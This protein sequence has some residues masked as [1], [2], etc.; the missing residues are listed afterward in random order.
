LAVECVDAWFLDGFSPAKNPEMW[1]EPVLMNIARASKRKATLATY[2]SA[3]WVRRGLQQVGFEVE[4]VT[5]F[6]SKREMV[7]GRLVGEDFTPSP[8][9]P[10]IE[11]ELMCN[12]EIYSGFNLPLPTGEGM[13]EGERSLHTSKPNNTPRTALIIG[14]GIAGCAAAYALAQRGISVTLFDKATQ[15]ASAASGNPRG[16]LHARFGAGDNPLQRFVLASYGHALGMLD[17]LLPADGKFR[18]E[19][20]LLQLA[21]NEIEIKRINKLAKQVW[22]EHLLRFVDA[23]TATQLAGVE[24]KFGGLWFSA[25]GWIVP[26]R[27]CENLLNDERITQR[28]GHEVEALEK[29][30]EGWRIKGRNTQGS[31]WE[32]EADVVLVC[33][34]HSAKKF[35]QFAHFPLIPVRGQITAVPQSQASRALQCV[36]CGDGYCAP[37]I[38]GVHVTGATHAFEDESS[39]VR[40]SDHAENL[41]NLAEY[42]PGLMQA[43]AVTEVEK[44]TGRAAIRCSAPGSI[45]LVGEVQE[46]LYCSLAH[47]TRGM[48]TAGLA[49]EL[50][51]AQICGQLPPLPVSI[52]EALAPKSRLR[53]KGFE[54]I[55]DM[56]GANPLPNPPPMGEG[57]KPLLR[58]S[59]NRTLSPR[60]RAGRG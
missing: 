49:G 41:A 52:V 14:A 5:G 13:R 51:A 44:L 26:P 56:V 54:E 3:G 1:S 25:A 6:G 33:C 21:C 2:T 22:P 34:A 50:L 32:A 35:A 39:E 55:Y 12:S 7:R 58:D 18:A 23:A 28:L 47:G 11:R 30:P 48:L 20:G 43:L 36:V 31:A 15:L 60:G 9:L 17:Q 10:R 37:A 4:R 42:A 38:D 24:M 16:I 29:T 46:G 19:C 45:P 40:T 8:T 27:I 53:N 57:T 59:E